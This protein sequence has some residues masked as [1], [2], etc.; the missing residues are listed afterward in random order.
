MTQ[1]A[2]IS[3][4]GEKKGRTHPKVIHSVA[5]PRNLSPVS[6][7]EA[8]GEDTEL[9]ARGADGQNRPPFRPAG[10]LSALCIGGE[11]C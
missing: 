3:D 7:G 4:K 5:C 10:W 6:G 1:S 8:F 2:Q 9:G 11:I